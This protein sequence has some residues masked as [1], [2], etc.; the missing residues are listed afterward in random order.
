MLTHDPKKRITPSEVLGKD[1]SST[2]FSI[3]RAHLNGTWKLVHLKGHNYQTVMGCHGKGNEFGTESK[4][5]RTLIVDSLSSVCLSI[6]RWNE[7]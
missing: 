7:K 6:R 2:W 5:T 3:F 1:L 4:R